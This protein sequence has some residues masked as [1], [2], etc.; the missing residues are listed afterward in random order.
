MFFL[1]LLLYR[2]FCFLFAESEQS[3]KS[4]HNT[5]DTN[6]ESST[7]WIILED[8]NGN[9]KLTNRENNQPYNGDLNINYNN[10]SCEDFV[11]W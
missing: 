3:N 5:A 11:E 9:G 8:L 6:P 7:N 2:I 1:D 10:H 4:K